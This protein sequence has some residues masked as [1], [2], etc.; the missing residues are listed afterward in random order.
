MHIVLE[1][2][3]IN[4]TYYAD[5]VGTNKTQIIKTIYVKDSKVVCDD[6]CEDTFFSFAMPS[7][8]ILK[9]VDSSMKLVDLKRF[10]ITFYKF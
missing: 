10:N 2:N 8:C 5:G 9:V 7:N 4:D 6:V 1:N 3:E